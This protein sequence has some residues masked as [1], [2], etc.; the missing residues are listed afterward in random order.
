MANCLL[1]NDSRCIQLGLNP[2]N[3]IPA[4][5]LTLCWNWPIRETKIGHVTDLIGQFQ[6]WFKFYAGILFKWSC[7]GCWSSRVISLYRLSRPDPTPTWTASKAPPPSRRRSISD[8]M[9]FLVRILPYYLNWPQPASL[10]VILSNVY[11]TNTTLE[12]IFFTFYY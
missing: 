3:K 9:K 2:I 1:D 10:W 8:E 5:N 12:E 6:H 4:N 7:P 11:V